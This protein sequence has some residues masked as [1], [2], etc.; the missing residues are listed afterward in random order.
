MPE[1][2]TTPL[3]AVGAVLNK[4]DTGTGAWVEI[5]QIGAM[6]W[7]GPSVEVIEYFALNSASL[8][9]NK[10]KGRKNAGQCTITMFYTSAQ[11]YRMKTDL[12]STT[13]FDY[14]IV[15]PNGEGL[16]FSGFPVELPLSLTADDV[17]QGDMVLE[18]DGQ[19]DFVS[20]AS[21]SP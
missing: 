11:F 12:E 9:I 2:T 7:S 16:E 5:A 18:I 1:P 10:A 17:M 20:S 8:Y 13:I 4:W 3:T 19:A 15:L 14:Q 21:S 6:D